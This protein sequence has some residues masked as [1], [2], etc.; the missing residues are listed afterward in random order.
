MLV[1]QFKDPESSTFTYIIAKGPNSEA[2]IIDPVLERTDEYFEF[3]G[4]NI[5]L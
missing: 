1:H 4:K 5:L 3:L 2:I